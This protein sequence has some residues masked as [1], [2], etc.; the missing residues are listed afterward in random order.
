MMNSY[1]GRLEQPLQ[2]LET[3]S[4]DAPKSQVDCLQIQQELAVLDSVR[5]Q[6]GCHLQIDV[7]TTYYFRPR[8]VQTMTFDIKNPMSL[9]PKRNIDS[10]SQ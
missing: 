3:F 5:F 10:W 6:Q 9:G 8:L 4:H 2:G 7:I 1:P